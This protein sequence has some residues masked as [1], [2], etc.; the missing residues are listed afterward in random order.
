[1]RNIN[2]SE[3]RILF[4]CSSASE[5]KEIE[6]MQCIANLNTELF[7]KALILSNS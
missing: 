4:L 3:E 2:F 5:R 7:K 1:M 6:E